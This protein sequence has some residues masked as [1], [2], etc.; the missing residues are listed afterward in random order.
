MLII[1]VYKIKNLIS[2]KF[3]II[4]GLSCSKEIIVSDEM[5]CDC[6]RVYF[7][8]FSILKILLLSFFFFNY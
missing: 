2:F 8:Y 6:C 4:K 7:T 5:I 3:E 1:F